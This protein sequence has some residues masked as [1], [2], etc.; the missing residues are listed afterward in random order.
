[1]GILRL[2]MELC[3]IN[4]FKQWHCHSVWALG[5]PPLWYGGGS[6]SVYTAKPVIA[7]LIQLVRFSFACLLHL[8]FVSEESQQAMP[9]AIFSN[10]EYADIHYICG[11]CDNN[12]QAVVEEYQQQFPKCTVAD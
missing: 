3:K 6:T 7:G 2:P 5:Y 12:A 1:M 11:Y 10:E 4:G 9:M 8:S